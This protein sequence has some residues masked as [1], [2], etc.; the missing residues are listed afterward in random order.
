MCSPCFSF[1]LGISYMKFLALDVKMPLNVQ[2]TFHKQASAFGFVDA[3][4]QLS[5]KF[6]FKCF[7]FIENT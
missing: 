7:L 2:S 3:A 5:F 6:F 1:L 4:N